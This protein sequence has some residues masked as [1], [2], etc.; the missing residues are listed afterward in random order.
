MLFANRE[1]FRTWLSENHSINK[2]IWL[3]FGKKNGPKTLTAD[4]AVEEALC[5]GWIDS[6]MKNLDDKTYIEYFCPRR[7]NS[8]WS[9]RNK[10]TVERLEA[11]GRMTDFGRAKVEEAK[12][13][14]KWYTETPPTVT[15]IQ[16]SDFARLF[17]GIEPACSNFSAMSFSVRRTYTL[18]YL[19]AKSEQTKITRLNKIIERLNKNLKPM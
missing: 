1:A 17:E 4:E 18:F 3:I 16:I 6:Q 9:E 15:E 14:G 13:N 5:F 12:K 2:G 11:Q 19:D 8:K 10:T 7:K